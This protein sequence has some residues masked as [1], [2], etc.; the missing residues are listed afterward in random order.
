LNIYKTM[1]VN[2]LPQMPTIKSWLD[3]AS[4][5]LHSVGITSSRLDAEIILANSLNKNRTYLH[6][7]ND[8]LLDKQ[9]L[10]TVDTFLAKRLSHEPIAYIFGYKEFYGRKFIVSQ[11]TLIPRPETEAIITTLKQLLPPNSFHRPTTKLIDIG[12]GCGCL[13]ITAKLEF[14]DISVQLS[15]ISEDA[16]EIA[17]Q[18]AKKHSVNVSIIQSDLLK[19]VSKKINIIIANL[20]YVDKTW[21]RSPETKYE[22]GL[23]LFAN[24]H[25]LEIIEKLLAQASQLLEPGGY[26]ILEA[27]PVQHDSITKYANGLF[28]EKVHQ[29]SYIIVFKLQ[30]PTN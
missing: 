24:K 20:P 23:A 6:A 19:N 18:N 21:E 22:P 26:I 11:S 27:D 9:L 13:G 29:D 15:D 4:K 17:R 30:D 3:N 1:S 7:H 14:P 10:K 5:Q 2:S 16:L 8:S 28:F 12:T 25:G